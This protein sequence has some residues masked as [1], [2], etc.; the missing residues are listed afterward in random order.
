MQFRVIRRQPLMYV[1]DLSLIFEVTNVCVIVSMEFNKL[2][3]ATY[4]VT[5]S[6]GK[7]IQPIASSI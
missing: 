5:I 1:M 4:D 2:C 3:K 7:G 6:G